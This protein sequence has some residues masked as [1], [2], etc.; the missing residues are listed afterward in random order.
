MRNGFYQC[1]YRDR[2]GS[3][4]CLGLNTAY[5]TKYGYD[6]QILRP[7]ARTAGR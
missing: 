7:L 4:E 5:V 6:E 2:C 3:K 1:V